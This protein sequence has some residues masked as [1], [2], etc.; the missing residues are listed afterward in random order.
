MKR[1]KDFVKPKTGDMVTTSLTIRADQM[2]FVRELNL[3]LSA[4]VR[5]YLDRLMEE[6]DRGKKDK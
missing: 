4:L 1:L 3:N 2:A 5:D 6:Q